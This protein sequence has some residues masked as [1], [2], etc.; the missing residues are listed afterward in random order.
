MARLAAQPSAFCRGRAAFRGTAA[1]LVGLLA[2]ACP[3]APKEGPPPAE[4]FE[5]ASAAPHALGALAGGTQAA[6]H[7]VVSPG[8]VV[9]PAPDEAAPDPDEEEDGGP[10]PLPD[11]G[12][13]SPEDVPL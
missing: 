13:G 9:H 2:S 5:V 6:P 8:G 1:A 11:A 7:A 4:S 12:A 3:S 10:P